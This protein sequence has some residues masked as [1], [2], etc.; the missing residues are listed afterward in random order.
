MRESELSSQ[1]SKHTFDK[2]ALPDR[3]SSGGDQHVRIAPSPLEH[4]RQ[5]YAIVQSDAFKARF[6]T[7]G[8][9]QR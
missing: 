3:G 9:H 6:A 7:G 1:L 2:I 4:S 8:E 5:G